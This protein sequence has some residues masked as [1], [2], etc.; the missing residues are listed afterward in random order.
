MIYSRVHDEYFS[1]MISE[2]LKY[3]DISDDERDLLGQMGHK[4]QIGEHDVPILNE[5][6]SRYLKDEVLQ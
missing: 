5:L 3:A 4:R 2:M 6:F 1:N